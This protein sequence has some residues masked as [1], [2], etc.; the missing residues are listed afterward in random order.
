MPQH[1]L[2][3]WAQQVAP[4]GF[5]RE[6]AQR[7]RDLLL[8]PLLPCE[9]GPAPGAGRWGGSRAFGGGAECWQGFGGESSPTEPGAGVPSPPP[10]LPALPTVAQRAPNRTA[11]RSPLLPPLL[12]ARVPRTPAPPRPGPREGED[13]WSGSAREA[14]SS[15]GALREASLPSRFQEFLRQLGDEWLEQPQ[16]LTSSES[17]HQRGVS[18]HCQRSPQCANCPL[19]PD[20]RG[21]SSYFQDSLK[22]GLL[23]QTPAL[24][25]LRTDHTQF[26]TIQKASKPHSI[27]APKLKAVLTHNCSGEGVGHRRRRYPLR[28]RF[29]DETLRDTALRYWERSCAFQQGV[30]ENQPATQSTASA[31]V[32]GSVKRWLESL[33]KALYSRVKEEPAATSPFNCPGLL[34][35]EPQGHLSEDSSMESSSPPFMS[36]VATPRQRRGL[37]TFLGPHRILERGVCQPRLVLHTILKPS[38]PKGYQLLLPS[39]PR[40]RGRR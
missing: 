5:P 15:S 19:L 14:P 12:L 39:V 35:P 28:V 23:H 36:R 1:H 13:W 11:L 31:R 6:G 24:G 21:Q 8:P 2:N 32:F 38:R 33:P 34:I 17:K 9:L 40:Q 26:P 10:R 18:E 16:P 37:K 30:I 25:P 20:L 7:P 27:Q 29:A 22:K 4:K 3:P